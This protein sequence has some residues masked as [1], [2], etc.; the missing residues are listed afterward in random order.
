MRA[1]LFKNRIAHI[2]IQR[3]NVFPDSFFLVFYVW[4]KMLCR[5]S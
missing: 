5:E 2:G 3:D 4:E 1:E